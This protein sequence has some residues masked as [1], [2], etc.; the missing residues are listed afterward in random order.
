[1]LLIENVV[2]EG[3]T[4]N[5]NK[6]SILILKLYFRRKLDILFI[7]LAV[8]AANTQN[9]ALECVYQ[10]YGDLYVCQLENITVLD[11]LAAV[12]ITGT[13][14]DGR[15]D[16]DVN[17]VAISDSNTPF[18]IQQLFT[19]FP[20]IIEL[21]IL[22]SNLETLIIPPEVQLEAIALIGNNITRIE[23][24]W[25]R[26][27]TEL[28]LFYAP[29]NQIVTIDEDAFEDLI[30]LE[31]L[32]LTD[33]RIQELSPRTLSNL[34]LLSQVYFA[35][36]LLTTMHDNTFAQNVNLAYLFM[37]DNQID[38]IH[39]RIFSNVRN[40]LAY[41]DFYGNQCIG[42]SFGVYPQGDSEWMTLNSA[43]RPCFNNYLGNENDV[44]NITM[45]FTGSLTIFDG[46]GNMMAR[47]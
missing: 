23:S 2:S 1:M 33:N 20:N 11:P 8:G 17:F 34:T 15:T 22:D 41:V 4:E 47:F 16:A 10:I 42:N 27:Q 5:K 12:T 24:G 37:N 36:N 26:N 40:N 32:L 14:L 43:L 29:D 39:P 45:Q 38:R 9:I 19:T 7:L 25:L 31:F 3:L 13:H 30:S 21:D 6:N 35:S 18:I 28:N 46:F 44:K